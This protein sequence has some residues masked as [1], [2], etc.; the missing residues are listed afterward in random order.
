MDSIGFQKTLGPPNAK[1]LTRQAFYFVVDLN[2]IAIFG[3]S[4]SW[5]KHTRDEITLRTALF[6]RISQVLSVL[7]Y[8]MINTDDI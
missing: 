5:L 2:I 1:L 7:T 8:G 4:H 3:D 6:Q